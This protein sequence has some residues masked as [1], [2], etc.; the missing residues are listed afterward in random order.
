MKRVILLALVVALALTGI[1]PAAAQTSEWS[2]YL[3]DNASQQLVRIYGDGTQQSIDLGLPVDSFVGQSAF[4]FSPDG[5]RVGYCVSSNTSDGSK[6]T[7]IV[8]DISNASTQSANLDLGT[9]QGCWVKFNAD[10]SQIAVGLVRYY[11]GDPD[12]DASVPPWSL[13]VVDAASSS[14]LYEMNLT[15]G[16]AIFNA[17]Q[18]IMPEVRYFANNQIIFAGLP[19]GTEGIPSSP[20]YFWQLSDDSL[21]PLDRWWRSGLDS[22]AG[23]GELVW[24]ELDSTLAA[25]DPGGP[26]PQANVVKLADKS[27]QERMI[28]AN[29]DWVLLGT[30]FIDNGRLLAINELQG[31][32]PNST[33]GSQPTRW[34][35]LDRSGTANVL[36]TTLGFSQ[37]LPAPDGYV[38]LWASDNS[39][40]PFMSLDYYSGREKT[41]LWQQ[42]GSGGMTWWLLWSSPT[43]TADGL[44][45]FPTVN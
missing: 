32:D 44:Q 27:G 19:W 39:A 13:L 37:I 2:V 35:A 30:K 23:T 18:T 21:Q 5:N 31:A 16:G 12:A 4:D 33:P 45:P 7:L 41:T 24:T 3:L 29:P 9:A 42:Q 10:A 14:S 17:Q 11:A 15:K 36:A 40:T 20:A 25:A 6:A 34:M 28:Y 22:L 1:I 43:T 38:I 8:R 26:L